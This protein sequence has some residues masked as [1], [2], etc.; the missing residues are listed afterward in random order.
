M[1]ENRLFEYKGFWV[2]ARAGSRRLYR[3]W[4]DRAD[5]QTRRVSLVTES[6]EEAADLLIEW[7][8]LNVGPHQAQ[9]TAVTLGELILRHREHHA[10]TRRSASQI[11]RSLDLWNAAFPGVTIAELTPGRLEDFG[12][13]LVAQGA[14][15]ETVR[16][17]LS[18]G[19]AMLNRARKRGELVTAP[20]VPVG[21]FARGKPRERLVTAEEVARLFMAFDKDWA[22]RFLMIAAGTGAR[23]E[24]I[25]EARL[26]QVDRDRRLLFLNPEG[27]DQT[28]K[29]R[30][31]IRIAERLLPWLPE[32]GERLVGRT[33][34][35]VELAWREARELA[36]LDAAIVP[37][38]FR[39][40]LHTLFWEEGVPESEIG[41]WFGRGPAHAMTRH[42]V[43]RRTQRAE[44]LINAVAA[45][46]KWLADIEKAI[47][48]LSQQT[49]DHE[50]E[51]SRACQPRVSPSPNPLPRAAKPLKLMVPL[52]WIEQST[53]PLP[54]VRSTTEL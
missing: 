5:R 35:P 32:E 9:P 20:Y 45:A 1:R 28:K 24:A 36:G 44:F 25:V 2:E 43:K 38:T 47:A 52:D 37:T 34:K 50:A 48:R 42:Y 54:R 16:R 46:D 26:D 49:G 18:D 8:T 13:R 29:V 14:A 22:R 41:D 6:P 21:A 10:G 4:Y 40:T 7:V 27:R 23:T 12:K 31:V 53:S 33:K 3:C 19:R 39:H 17:V 11:H 15:T 51:M 30:P